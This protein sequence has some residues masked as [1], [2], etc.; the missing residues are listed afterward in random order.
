[1]RSGLWSATTVL[2]MGDGCV[3]NGTWTAVCNQEPRTWR[4]DGPPRLAAQAWDRRG[5]TL[6]WNAPMALDQLHVLGDAAAGGEAGEQVAVRLVR[7]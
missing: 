3:M 4:H 1:M 6:P 5:T 7:R 2:A